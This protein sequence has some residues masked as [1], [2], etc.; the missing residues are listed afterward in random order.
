MR[1]KLKDIF[2][3]QMGKTPS[4]SNL[5]YWNTTDYKWISI[6]DLTKTSK[7]I[8]E[9][10]EYLSKSAIKDS[11][12]KV[13]PANT[14]VMSFKLSIGKTAITKEDMYSNEAIMAFK[15]KHVINIIP[16]YIFYLFKYKNWEECSNKAV[17][18]KTLNKATLS[19]IEVEICS[20]EKQRQIVNI[21]DKIMSAVDGRKQELQLLDELIKARF[22]EMFGDLKTNSKMWQIVGF[23]ECAVI[24]TNMIHNFQG[25]EDYPHIGI[26][27]IEK[28]T[29]KLIGYRT[30]SEDGV[31]SGKYLFTPQHI[32]YSKIRP[33][34][35]KVALPDFD[36]LCS[37]DAYPILVKKEICNRE[38]MGYTLRNKY[39]LDYILAFSSRTNLPKVNKK[40]VEGFK[41]P[42]PPMGLQNQ[43]ADFVHQVDKSKFDTMTFAPIYAIINLYLHT[44]FYQGRR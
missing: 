31:V 23:N 6:A 24:D 26:D 15:D 32:I 44:Y 10:K 5:E 4:R 42:L 21:L 14:V 30:I 39:F 33:N 3:L 43:F 18:G 38:Y 19:E 11:G 12:I 17:M 16:E 13:I 35:N 41:L 7:Y 36:G 29:G 2:D 40:Q 22:V 27:S 37:A 28:E 8:F 34:L 20:I 25:Y 9:T 1:V